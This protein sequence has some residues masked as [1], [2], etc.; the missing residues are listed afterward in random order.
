MDPQQR[1]AKVKEIVA[2]HYERNDP[3]GWFET[4]YSTAKGDTSLIPW[5][6]QKP[7]HNLTSWLDRQRIDGGGRSCVVV[8]CGL[9]DDA[10]ELARR[11]FSASAFDISGSAID[12]CKK[13]FPR[14][15]VNYAQA[16][17]FEFQ[18]AFDFVFESYT[19]QALPRSLRAKAI[20]AV[21]NLVKPRG[22]ELLVICRG[23]EDH[24]EE[25][26]LPWPLSHAE[27]GLFES[28]HG[29]KRISLENY[30]DDERDPPVRRF[31]ALFRKD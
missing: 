4:L 6:D 9:G 18:G 7:N 22:G 17:L 26:S 30:F 12:W 1:E 3:I 28:A 25:G 13:R 27:I 19:I 14:S 2:T 8:G 21:A 24:E 16:D 31:R 29:L 23:R 11:G 5:A 10:E 20:E 15:N